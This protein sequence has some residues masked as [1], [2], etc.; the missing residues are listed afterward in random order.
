[1][2][3]REAFGL[4]LSLLSPDGMIAIHITNKHLNLRPLLGAL[5]GE[6]GLQAMI[7][8]DRVA[9][10]HLQ[11]D[12]RLSSV[13][14]V[15]TGNPQ[16]QERMA[17]EPGWQRLPADPSFRVWTDDYVNILDVLSW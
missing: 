7:R 3:T 12:G 8:D 14:V 15:L 5:A 13:Y 17:A 1:L 2:V 6:L 4:Y 10:D 9:G 16:V 11:N